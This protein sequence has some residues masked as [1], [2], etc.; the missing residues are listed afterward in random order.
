MPE[1]FRRRA[2]R[3]EL[4]GRMSLPTGCLSMHWIVRAFLIE[5]VF[6]WL[7]V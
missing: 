1:F 4:T 2:E 3:D 6:G 7:F 5:R